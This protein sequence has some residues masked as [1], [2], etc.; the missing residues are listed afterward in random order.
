MKNRSES[1]RKMVLIAMLAAISYL[2]VAYME[3]PFA[4]VTK[5][6]WFLSHSVN[7]PYLRIPGFLLIVTQSNYTLL[8]IVFI[9][10]GLVAAALYGFLYGPDKRTFPK[11]YQK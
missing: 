6:F 7:L 8:W 11:L 10:V 3:Y 1:V 5:Q 9:A 2:I 4:V